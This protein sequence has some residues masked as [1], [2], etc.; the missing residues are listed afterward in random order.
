MGILDDIDRQAGIKMANGRKN[1]PVELE[2]NIL[3]ETPKAFLVKHSGGERWLPKSQIDFDSGTC[4]PEVGGEGVIV[5]PRWLADSLDEDSQPAK[6]D[7]GDVSIPNVVCLRESQKALQVLVG[8]QEMWIPKTQIRPT[9]GVLYDGDRG[10][11]VVSAWIAGE[12]G[13]NKPQGGRDERQDEEAAV[14]SVGLDDLPF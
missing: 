2:V 8:E 9:S 1:E 7:G 5:I 13:L 4:D 10:T 3:K 14:E 11:L 6:Q 12:K